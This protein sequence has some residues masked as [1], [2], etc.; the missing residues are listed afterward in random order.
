MY[1]CMYVCM[2]IC[3]YICMYVMY[4]CIQIVRGDVASECFYS[5]I[6]NAGAFNRITMKEF[7]RACV[8]VCTVILN[9]CRYF[10][11]NEYEAETKKENTLNID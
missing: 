9:A 10:M 1:V 11:Q 7:A 8:C 5:D 6:A 4:I 2:Y 3:M